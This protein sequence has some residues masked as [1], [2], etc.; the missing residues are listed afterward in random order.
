MLTQRELICCQK[1][2][3]L[4]HLVEYPCLEDQISC[5][6]Q[7]ADFN[8]VCSRRI[9]LTISLYTHLHRSKDVEV[10]DDENRY[11]RL[12]KKLT[13]RDCNNAVAA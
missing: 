7:H 9:V 5:I 12:Q 6:T 4:K 2:E 3:E 1:I 11:G 13:F 8:H 10:P